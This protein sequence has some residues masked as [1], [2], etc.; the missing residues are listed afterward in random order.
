MHRL[1]TITITALFV[2]LLIYSLSAAPF[3]PESPMKVYFAQSVHLPQNGN[4]SIPHVET[5]LTGVAPFVAKK[6]I[7][8]LPSAYGKAINCTSDDLRGPGLTA[9]SWNSAS[10][11]PSPDA[12]AA[13]STKDWIQYTAERT[14]NTSLRISLS[15]TNSRACRIFFDSKPASGFSVR[16]RLKSPRAKESVPAQAGWPFPEE[17]IK[18]LNLWSRSWDRTFVVDAFWKLEAGETEGVKGRVACEWAEY[19]SGAAGGRGFGGRIP[20]LEEVIAGLPRWALVT[21][22]MEGLVEAWTT[23]EV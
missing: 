17:G 7:P 11:F 13:P 20:A 19:E 5:T 10:L 9:C 18:Q 21:K 15:G 1:L 4:K 8:E 22:R 16:P 23:F 14:S 6:L 12:L 3:T 2:V